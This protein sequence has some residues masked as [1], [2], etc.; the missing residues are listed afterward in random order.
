MTVTHDEWQSALAR[1]P[2]CGRAAVVLP[3]PDRART[4]RQCASCRGHWKTLPRDDIAH[5][6]RRPGSV[7]VLFTERLRRRQPP[8]PG[9]NAP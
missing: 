7:E 8:P 3:D 1:C 9:R 6:P 4:R 2:H 5:V